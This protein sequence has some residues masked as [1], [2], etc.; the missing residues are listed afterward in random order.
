MAALAQTRAVAILRAL[1]AP[2][3]PGGVQILVAWQA[4]EGTPAA[5]HN[6][7]A[8]TL[9]L[10]GSTPVNAA[11]VQAYP[12]EAEGIEATRLTLLNGRY[13]DL[14]AALRTGDVGAFLAHPAEIATWGTDPACIARALGRPYTPP[15]TVG[16]TTWVFAA[17]VIGVPWLLVLMHHHHRR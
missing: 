2:V 14:V 10:P 15:G 11:G 13:P 7:L 5:W 17:M 8:T 16:P 3:T 4:C 6:P 1:G 9:P 12:S